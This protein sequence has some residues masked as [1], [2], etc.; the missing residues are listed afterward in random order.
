MTILHVIGLHFE[1]F[2]VAAWQIFDGNFC[3]SIDDIIVIYRPNDRTALLGLC[4]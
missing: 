1:C 3:C 4:I 2:E